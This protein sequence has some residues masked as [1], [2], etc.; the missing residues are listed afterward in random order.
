M[1]HNL[2]HRHARCR[3]AK[4][5]ASI[6]K[7]DDGELGDDHAHGAPEVSGRS[8]FLTIFGLSLVICCIV[9]MTRLAPEAE[10]NM[11]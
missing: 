10:A 2:F 3:L 11:L 9:T 4:S 8:H 7:I 1:S 6:G 5:R